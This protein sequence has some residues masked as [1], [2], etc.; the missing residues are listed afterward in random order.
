VDCDPWLAAISALADGEDPGIDQRLIDAHLANCPSCRAFLAAAR[1]QRRRSRVTTAPTM[2]NLSRR[3]VKLNALADRASRWS[4]VRGLLAI[5]A[6]QILV[7]STPALLFGD[8]S[9]TSPHGA[10]HL[11]AF[12]VAYA[13]GLLV[14][15]ARPARARTMLPVAGV[16]AAALTASGLVDLVDDATNPLTEIGHL[17]ELLSVLLVWMLARPA[18]SPTR[19]RPALP[20]TRL[21]S[22]LKDARDVG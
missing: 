9:G 10:R 18:P 19:R 17:P 8:E 22:E 16:L 1:D 13:V 14:V 5:T 12:S 15:S 11:G 3:V 7:F 21:A 20:W 2:P 4:L 6:I